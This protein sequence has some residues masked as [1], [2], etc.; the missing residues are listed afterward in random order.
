MLACLYMGCR[1]LRHLQLHQPAMVGLSLVVLCCSP[2][3]AL[4]CM[5]GDRNVLLQLQL[6]LICAGLQVGCS[7]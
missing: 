2:L 3:G 7:T 6:L 4:R 5:A 1:I